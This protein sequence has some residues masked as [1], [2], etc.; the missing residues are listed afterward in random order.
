MTIN[1]NNNKTVNYSFLL[2]CLGALT[3]TA[4]ITAGIITTCAASGAYATSATATAT[5]T[6]AFLPVAALAMLIGA[7]CL[8]P[9][10]FGRGNLH[11]VRTPQGNR[12]E[13]NGCFPRR[14]NPNRYGHFTQSSA[15]AP[16][17]SQI[18]T[19]PNAFLNT[20]HGH[21]SNHSHGGNP[22]NGGNHHGHN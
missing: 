20:A 15:L 16:T 7:V 21:T 19:H 3:A 8:L 14:D 6:P 4:V 18:H 13:N 12:W 17:S 1:A 5:V 2:K 22:Q 10:L 11:T 9:F